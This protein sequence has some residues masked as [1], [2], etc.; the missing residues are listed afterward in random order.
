MKKLF[1]LFTAAALCAVVTGAPAGSTR[2]NPKAVSPRIIEVGT[3]PL[4]TLAKGGKAQ[5]EIVLPANAN[6]T[7]RYAATE[8]KNFLEQIIGS[9]VPVVKAPTGKCTAFLLGA[10]GAKTINFDL[11]GIDRDGYI[12]Q[13]AGKNIV[14]AGTDDPQGHPE[15]R[16][17]YME[18]G[19]LNGV[20]EFLERIGGVRFYFPGEMGTVVPRKA[21]W[22]VGKIN[23]LDRPDN[24]FRRTYCVN[25]RKLGVSDKLVTPG[26]MNEAELKRLEALRIRESTLLI[27]NCHGL[28]GLQLVKRF[29]KTKPEFFALRADKTRHD[30][31]R[32]VRKDDAD[33]QLCFTNEELKEVVYQDTKA[34]FTGK[35]AQS[36]GISVWHKQFFAGPFFN[37]MPNDALYPC[38]CATC[39]K[40]SLSNDPKATPAQ[41]RQAV[42]NHIWKFKSDIA[43]RL[44]KE[45]IPGFVTVMAYGSYKPI[46]TMDLPSN[47]IVHLA[48]TGPWKECNIGP[49]AR[50][51]E[52]LKAWQ[53]K[54]GAK[55]YLWTYTTKIGNGMPYLPSFTPRAVGSF[56]KKAAPYSFGAFLEAELDY[57]IFN[58][59]NFYVFGKVMWDTNVDVDALFK[60]HFQL[61]YGAAAG[62]MEEFYNT[63]ETKWLKNIMANIRETS[64]GPKAVLPSQI[65]VWTKIYSPAEIKR[66]TALFDRAEKLTAKD[67]MANKRVK[68]MRKELFGPVLFGMQQFHKRNNDKTVW[69]IYA[70]APAS[71]VTIDGKLDDAAWKKAESV[72]LIPHRSHASIGEVN[73]VNTSVK[74]LSDKDYFY[75]AFECEEPFTSKMLCAPRKRDEI[76]TWRDNLVEIFIAPEHSSEI[77]YQFMFNNRGN[78]VD[79]RK[80]P[81]VL[82]NKWNCDVVYQPGVVPGKKWIAEVK[83][84]RKS[85]PELKGDKIVI[86]FTRGRVLNEG[87]I[88]KIPHYTWFPFQKQ[89]AE[90]CGT[91][92]LGKR[93]ASQSAV[94]TCDFKAP[95]RGKRFCGAW[96]TQKVLNI[97]DK[98]FRTAGRSVR[99][100]PVDGSHLLRQYLTKANLK[101]STRYRLSFFVKLDNVK[102]KDKHP[103]S[104]FHSLIRFG[105]SGESRFLV[106]LPGQSFQGTS[107]WRRMEY[108]FTT[109]ADVN[110]KGKAYIEFGISLNATGTAWLDQVEM[111]PVASK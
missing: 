81:G 102:G 51:M 72:H 90:N 64:D 46:P 59:M 67:P 15:K 17:M 1:L 18:R 27:P 9:K 71:P 68:F 74:M 83:I 44:Q 25:V 80:S 33:G 45:G 75:F 3:A 21:D 78:V 26:N 28:R 86:N 91:A 48:L 32:I 109:P 39:Q 79:I 89:I 57:W 19:T 24:Q 55:T 103:A 92:V 50:D 30:G 23:I 94:L 40:V 61:M 37:I 96:Y 63:I 97:D 98:V 41:K 12:I 110:S 38:R 22:S 76:D 20:Y 53:K 82:S 108:E 104:G 49:Q 62:E 100:E 11:A 88:V 99:L 8:L 73:E 42:S 85:M 111:V 106:T 36:R 34:F 95:V 14:I 93:P 31:S 2:F 4:H 52:L 16:V 60:E 101:P 13:S 77:L 107:D 70:D 87:G 6:R 7:V 69:T 35:S 84:P 47:M 105:G 66:L 43:R 10:E 5:C 56:F 54:L 65:D 58:F 29:A